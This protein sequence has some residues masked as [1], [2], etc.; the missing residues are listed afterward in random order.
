[1]GDLALAFVETGSG[2]PLLLHHGAESHK[3]QHGLLTPH[4]SP[5]IR[6]IAYDQRDVGD[7]DSAF[8]DYTMDGLVEDCVGLM[9]ALGLADAHLAGF[10]FGGAIALNVALRHPERVRSLVVG[11]TPRSFARPS[12]FVERALTLTPEERAV[13]MLDASI[14][15]RAQR[16]E[17][18]M[19]VV[20]DLLRGRV[21][22]PGSRRAAA[23]TTHHLTRTQLA[24]IAVPT[25]LVYGSD[26]PVVPPSEGRELRAALPAAELVELEEA[27]HGVAL[28]HPARV[29][30]LINDWIL[31]HRNTA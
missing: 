16:D 8:R 20:N 29:A 5:A 24:S 4:L 7:S 17:R 25:L 1:M 12:P 10:S 30:G 2:E 28:E 6:A 26:D 31:R 3:G 21:T 19:G 11:A 13:V 27:R 14:S 9:D 18:L 22:A 23:I 15:P